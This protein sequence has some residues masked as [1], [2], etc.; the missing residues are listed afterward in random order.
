VKPTGNP[1]GRPRIHPVEGDHY[2][3]P[4]KRVV[5]IVKISAGECTCAYVRTAHSEVEIGEIVSLSVTWITRNA[6]IL[7]RR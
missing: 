3:L 7:Y 5:S 1:V 6:E 4:S 2:R